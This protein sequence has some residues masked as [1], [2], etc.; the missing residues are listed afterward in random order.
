M[1]FEGRGFKRKRGLYDFFLQS[2]NSF[3]IQCP[4]VNGIHCIYRV[5]PKIPTKINPQ[6]FNYSFINSGDSFERNNGRS[7]FEF[8]INKISSFLFFYFD[9]SLKKKKK[10]KKI[11][12]KTL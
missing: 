5:G 1:L 11:G 10:K 3:S 6:F 9:V 12:E 8:K 2:S 4:N 7:T